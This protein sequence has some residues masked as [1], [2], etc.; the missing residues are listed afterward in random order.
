M[1]ILIFDSDPW[2]KNSLIKL[3][4]DYFPEIRVIYHTTTLKETKNVILIQKPDVVFANIEKEPFNISDFIEDINLVFPYFIITSSSPEYAFKQNSYE[5]IAHLIKPIRLAELTNVINIAKKRIKKD[6]LYEDT[7]NNAL[8]ESQ[9]IGFLEM[10]N[11]L[12][13]RV[14]QIVYLQSTGEQTNLYL[15]DGSLKKSDK[16][17]G[18]YEKLLPKNLFLRIHKQYLVNMSY[19][20]NAK[21]IPKT[22]ILIKKLD[23]TLPV[24]Y[25]KRNS[26]LRFL[27]I[28]TKN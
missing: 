9:F 4:S 22:V 27:K 26:L 6:R 18:E 25:R 24:S 20:T 2:S 5:V 8:P 14:P 7:R 15:E 3:L 13:L 11:I 10:G 12:V 19:V 23:A 1:K 17:I 16:R 21:T 28:K